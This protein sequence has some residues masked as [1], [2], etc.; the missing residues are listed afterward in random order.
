MVHTALSKM[1]YVCGGAQAVIEALI[2]VVGEDG[3]IMM[4]AQSWKNL[5]NAELRLMN[6][7]ILVD[8]A[9]DWIQKYRRG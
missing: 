3:T 2:E 8:F 5:G 6:Q 1:G 7:K 9:V 4:P